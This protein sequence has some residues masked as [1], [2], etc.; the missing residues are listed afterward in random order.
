MRS[1]IPTFYLCVCALAA[2]WPAAANESLVLLPGTVASFTVPPAAPFPAL[3]AT[4]LEFRINSWTAPS[5]AATL[6]QNAGFT[7]QLR[8]TG[9]LCAADTTDTLPQYGDQMCANITGHPDVSVRVQRDTAARLLRYEVR[10]SNALWTAVTYCGVPSQAFA[11]PINTIGAGSWAG[12]GALGDA[13]THVQLAWLKWYS[14]L[15]TPGAALAEYTPADLADWRFEQD[16]ANQATGNY[17]VVL[18]PLTAGPQGSAGAMEGIAYAPTPVYSPACSA[19]AAQVLRASQGGMLDGS[20]SYALDGGSS[21]SFAWSETAGQSAVS[22]S[23]TSAVQPQIS[24]LAVGSYTFQLTVTDGSGQ[25]AACSVSD[26]AVLQTLSAQVAAGATATV[27]LPATPPWTTIGAATSAMRWEMRIHS[28]GANWPVNGPSIGPVHLWNQG[29][30]VWAETNF[31]G[32]AIYNNGVLIPGCCAGRSDTLIR[33]QRDVVNR[34]YTF[35][36]CDT[37]GGNCLSGTSAISSFG[38][39][40][41]AGFPITLNSGYQISFLR[42]F[43]SVVPLGTPIPMSGATGDLAD[44][45]FEGTLADSSGHGLNLA[46]AVTFA[47]SPVYPPMCSPGTQQTFRAGFA[48]LLDGSLSAPLDGG[49]QLGYAWQE[50]SGPSTVTWSNQNTAQPTANGLVFGSYV[51]QLTA[52]DGSGQSSSCSVKD[53]AVAS[54]DNGVVTTGNAVLDGI[55]GPMMRLGANPWPWYDDRH[56]ALADMQVQNLNTAAYSAYFDV[57]A[58]GTVSVT[59]GSAHV[60]G[61]GTTFST[62]FCQGPANPTVPQANA[63]I[64]V[65]YPTGITGQTGRRMQTVLSCQ[66]DTQLTMGN[67]G[68]PIAWSGVSDNAGAPL[69]YSSATD[70]TYYAT[71]GPPQ[72]INYYDNVFGLYALY[73][74]SGLDDYLTAARTLADRVWRSPEMDRGASCSLATQN[75]FCFWPNGISMLGLVLRAMDNPP[76]DMWPGMHGIWDMERYLIDSYYPT[77]GTYGT[78]DTRAMA[79]DLAGI[80]YCAL[81]DTDATYRANCQ[82]S[83]SKAIAGYFTQRKW[84]DAAGITSWQTFGSNNGSMWGSPTTVTLSYGSTAVTG[85]GTAWNSAMNASSIWFFPGTAQPPNN[86]AGD[87]VYY[88]PTVADARHLTLNRPY[89]DASCVPSCTRG[90][91]YS[92]DLLGYGAQPF[93]E[94]ILGSAFDWAAKA[95]AAS[96]PVNS[97]L[98]RSY[99][100]DAANWVKTYGYQ[101]SMKGPYYGAQFINCP[102]PIA[103]GTP[104][105]TET[106]ADAVRTMSAESWRGLQAAYVD[107]GDS[108]LKSWLD[109]LFNAMFAKPGSCPSG[110][111]VCVSD[112]LY[113]DPIDA[114]GYMVPTTLPPPKWFG[115]FF[116][117]GD[118]E[119]WPGYRIGGAQPVSMTSQ[120]VPVDLRAVPG[121]VQVRATV[122]APTGLASPMECG[123]S[124]CRAWID[125]R[126]GEHMVEV[127]Y[128]DGAGRALKTVRTHIGSRRKD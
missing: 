100:V 56:K 104:Y 7:I 81:Y 46:G 119:A 69:Q 39:V 124:A 8:S 24:G 96:D 16:L 15:I 42:W 22:F 17:G 71:Q 110:S 73:Y 28:F 126:L 112:G 37:T 75:G 6:F 117:Y 12:A 59:A 93:M 9:E 52:T 115:A 122:V 74:R 107:S 68:A 10:A 50:V 125:R 48:A 55:F 47:G 89:Q 128:L 45:E 109:T 76:N 61:Y 103:D 83:V 5:S 92:V 21:L 90:W 23:S 114:G 106:P 31:N 94:A 121:A 87:P 19:G 120:D 4:R 88:T 62:T 123:S 127:E 98:A 99:A 60:T 29:S 63:A 43:S 14:A 111:G 118:T 102:A 67:Y 82:S 30:G 35:E 101:A 36:V 57:A 77:S 3:G 38:P 33:I 66:S 86:S 58:P 18:G 11:C 113:V 2:A 25:T 13:Q 95:I 44:W 40:S 49:N 80:A 51:F 26:T 97:A 20:G 91:A 84:V 70:F 78:G 116:G 65:W 79:F 1:P 64:T 108:G 85:N 27:Q 53:G 105:C 34:R 72:A 32:D 41:W 54:D